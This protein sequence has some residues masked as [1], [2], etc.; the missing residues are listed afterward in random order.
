MRSIRNLGAAAAAAL[1]ALSGCGG[2]G[3]DAGGGAAGGPAGTLRILALGG[4]GT[5]TDGTGG[6]G[7]SVRVSGETASDVAILASGTLD[8][9]FTAPAAAVRLGS[10]PRTVTAGATI[11][12]DAN[13]EI[14]GDVRPAEAA[15]GLHVL[16][17]VTLELL[18]NADRDD[19]SPALDA[20]TLSL[21]E[22]V[23]VEG[24]IR[25]RESEE[26]A[27]ATP[28]AALEVTAREI[29]IALGGRIDASGAASS[30][31]G[32]AAPAAGDITLAASGAVVVRGEILA[33][34]G[35]GAD[36]GGAG[37]TVTLQTTG[38]GDVFVTG[39]VDVSGGAGAAG[40]GGNGG[41]VGL[42]AGAGG[43]FLGGAITARGG[44]GALE[45]GAGGGM[46]AFS[47]RSGTGGVVSS[48][49]IELS[50]GT[51]TASLA[52]GGAGGVASFNDIGRLRVGGA[53]TCRGGASVAGQG[54]Q[55]GSV[56]VGA[57]GADG[58]LGPRARGI[59]VAASIDVSG[60]AGGSGGGG[61]EVIIE[62]IESPQGTRP[63]EAPVMLRGYALVDV[64]GGRGVTSTAETNGGGQIIV[65]DDLA[66]AGGLDR[67]GSVRNEA[68]L[69]AVGGA[70]T[71]GV[72]GRGGVCVVTS[73]SVLTP[74]VNRG[75]IDVSGGDGA[76]GGDGGT[77]VCSGLGDSDNGAPITAR[78]GV[79]DVREGGRGGQTI[80]TTIVGAIRNG[81]PLLADGGRGATT[82]GDGG[83]IIVVG[84]RT[85][86]SG[87]L[88]ARGG[89]GV[90]GGS[91]ARGGGD[92]PPV[93]GIVVLST[94][95]VS[96]VSGRLAATGGAGTSADGLDGDLHVDGVLIQGASLTR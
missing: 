44:A 41:A 35:A 27:Q 79:G 15:T 40:S 28:T 70:S 38:A 85:S 83:T 90:T 87:D 10:N 21:A 8:V 68:A 30:A 77:G 73:A 62:L 76:G 59:E 56:N 12:P 5:A 39:S 55:G 66:V 82:G 37:G 29:A 80:V 32:T 67:G 72:G 93:N 46:G 20:I 36:A 75:E 7:G 78:G 91:G 81:A 61:G 2:G 33:L 53:I 6:V 88:F 54:G 52:Q 23:L 47:S 25:A 57:N 96:D 58:L 34:G 69:R 42:D 95:G 45:G 22:G 9:S 60:G 13:G 43:I 4:E 16:P 86:T 94:A 18:V 84:S 63:G 26:P 14:P 11:R 74:V 3:G 64:S 89:D 48:A 65:V 19:A 51:A 31:T 49:R 17:G 24:V 1:A 71:G 50:G 92:G